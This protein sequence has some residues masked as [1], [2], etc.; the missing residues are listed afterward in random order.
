MLVLAGCVSASTDATQTAQTTFA[1]AA[2]ESSASSTVTELEVELVEVLD[3]DTI[4]VVI[5]GVAERVRL[6]GINTPEAGEC[7]ADEATAALAT[8]VAGRSIRLESDTSDRDRYDR[9]LRY[10]WVDDLF[11]NEELVF[12]GFAIARRYEP[13]TAMAERFEA[14]Q[15]EARGSAAGLW[16]TDACGAPSEDAEVQIVEIVYDAPGDDGLNLNGEWVVIQ[17]D[18]SA[19]TDMTGWVLKDESSSHRFSFPA[20]FRVGPG[21]Q[22]QVFSGCGTDTETALFWCESGSA[23]WN[24]SG[25][26]AFLLD[27]AGNTVAILSY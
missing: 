20:G 24:N 11:A 18:G 16:A 8:L 13:D 7:F 14:A 21:Q 17:N 6:I 12:G 25:D 22:V 2:R 23:I 27:P 5:D 15:A 1:T 10:V 4:A 19:P 9:L 3:G 26:T